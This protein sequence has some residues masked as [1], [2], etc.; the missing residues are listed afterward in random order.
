MLTNFPF[1]SS[2]FSRPPSSQERAPAGGGQGGDDDEEEE[3]RRQQQQ[4][5]LEAASSARLAQ[6]EGQRQED[7]RRQ[8]QDALNRQVFPIFKNAHLTK[9]KPSFFYRSVGSYTGRFLVI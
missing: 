6:L 7:Q 8:I 2:P 4:A 1:P 9:K 3:R 5:D